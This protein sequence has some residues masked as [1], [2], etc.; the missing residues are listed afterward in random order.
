MFLPISTVTGFQGYRIGII[1]WEIINILQLCLQINSTACHHMNWACCPFFPHILP[2]FPE[3]CS[4][5][6]ASKQFPLKQVLQMQSG[7]NWTICTHWSL[8]VSVHNNEEVSIRG[9]GGDGGLRE[10]HWNGFEE[11]KVFFL[12]LKGQREHPKKSRAAAF[13]LWRGW[14]Y[15]RC[16]RTGATCL[17]TSAAV[18]E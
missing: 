18:L 17:R 15:F 2:L 7:P 10:A 3:Q 1:R 16:A 9:C 5:N 13:A 8:R 12:G 6:R 4:T 14:I 11:R